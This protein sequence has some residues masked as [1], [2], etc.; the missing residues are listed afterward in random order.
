[1]SSCY[2]IL[3][4]EVLNRTPSYYMCGRLYLPIFLL[5][6]GLFTLIKM[7]SLVFLT[8]VCPSLPKM[9]KLSNV[10]W[11]GLRWTGDHISEGVFRYSLKLL[12]NILAGSSMDSSSDMF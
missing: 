9:L 8:K 1:M 12:P 10:V 5:R 11:C 7:D 2:L 6:V 4:S 3:S